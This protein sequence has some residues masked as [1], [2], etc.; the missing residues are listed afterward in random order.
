MF[1]ITEGTFFVDVTPFTYEAFSTI[2]LNDGSSNNFIS[3][4]KLNS[5]QFR[6]RVTS[7]GVVQAQIFPT[8]TYNIRNKFI[9]TFKENQFKFYINGSLVSTDTSGIVPTGLSE[10][11]F[12]YGNN[13]AEFTGKVHGTR[14]YDKVL[15]EAEAIELTTL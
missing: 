10:L 12:N 3:I 9:I 7:G 4:V 1:D 14:V 8:I 11:S 5:T 2:T 13:T 6:L 15:T